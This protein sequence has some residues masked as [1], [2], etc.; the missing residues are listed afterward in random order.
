MELNLVGQCVATMDL[1]AMQVVTVFNDK[2]SD[3][4]KVG[5]EVNNIKVQ[6]DSGE[7]VSGDVDYVV[8]KVETSP[9]FMRF[10]LVL[11]K[12]D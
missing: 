10:T 8:L 2:G 1:G 12:I 11:G 9:F 6:D 3:S 5:D 4:S 7:W